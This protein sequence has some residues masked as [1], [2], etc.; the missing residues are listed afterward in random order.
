M[1][2]PSLT[3]KPC[4]RAMRNLLLSDRARLAGAAAIFIAMFIQFYGTQ[5]RSGLRIL[6]GDTGDGLFVVFVH[7]H[8]YQ[9]F[10]GRESFLNPT[11]FFPVKGVFGYS[12][13]FLL[14]QVFYAPLR[15]FGVEPFLSVQLAFMAMS[16]VGGV[17]FAALLIRFLGV[18]SWLAV[19]CAAI[20]AFGHALYVKTGHPQHLAINYLPVA[21]YLA[22]SSLFAAASFTAIAGCAFSAGLVFGLTFVSGYYAAWFASF[23]LMFAVPVFAYLNWAALVDFVRPERRRVIIGS[24]AGASGFGLGAIL[25]LWIYLP[26]IAALRNLTRVNFLASAATFR[27]IVNVSDTNLIWGALLRDLHL[28][29]MHRLQS[30]ELSLAVTPLLV[31]ATLVGA[32]LLRRGQRSNFDRTAIALATA[33]LFSYVIV[34]VLTITYQGTTSLFF[35]VQKIVPGAVAIRVGFRSQVVSALFM[36]LAFAVCAE[37][38]L[39]RTERPAPRKNP[40]TPATASVAIFTIAA[41]LNLEQVDLRRWA[42]LDRFQEIAFLDATPSPPA[43][44]RVFAIYNDGSRILQA[45]NI[46]AMRIGQRFGLPTVNG[47]SG[48]VPIGWDLAGVWDPAYLD[49]VKKWLHDK[50]VAGPLCYYVVP[51]KTWTIVD[52]DDLS[53]R[54]SSAKLAMR[55][56]LHQRWVSIRQYA[57]E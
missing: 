12:D 52:G 30:V 46:D 1:S 53:Y 51:T 40:I 42:L 49:R 15:A 21:A 44:C 26:A 34:Y 17:A 55:Q 8:V 35:L 31:L 13:T 38:W 25:L 6:N 23:F 41:L 54:L 57:W 10:L 33:V 11:F 50:G 45:I 37:A 28:I 20:F 36:T 3:T 22:L 4:S 18:R 56:G 32:V 16:I 43:A 2:Q 39:R 19:V 14:N 47:Y 48:G 9:S 27:D 24:L 29:P 7:E 5:L